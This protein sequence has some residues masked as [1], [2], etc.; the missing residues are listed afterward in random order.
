MPVL[1][2]LCGEDDQEVIAAAIK[3]STTIGRFVTP[4][5]YLEQIAPLITKV[6]THQNFKKGG[7]RVLDALISGTDTNVL[8][9]VFDDR[10]PYIDSLLEFIDILGI[11]AAISDEISSCL[12]H[13][14]VKIS[15]SGKLLSTNNQ[16]FMF[17]I[18]IKQLS[19][20]TL[21]TATNCSSTLNEIA[22]VL[23]TTVANVHE[24]FGFEILQTCF[25]SLVSQFSIELFEFTSIVNGLETFIGTRRYI[26]AFIELLV[27]FCKNEVPVQ[28]MFGLFN[29]DVYNVYQNY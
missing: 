28:I 3:L 17:K 11:D 2:R 9:R 15:N 6:G 29:L 26:D 23:N 14:S 1:S 12:Y 16:S 5:I 13:V 18:C 19:T 25:N 24:M 4:D 21:I 7:M 27:L 20:S 10:R 8:C 22:N